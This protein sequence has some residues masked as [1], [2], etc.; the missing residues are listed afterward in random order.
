M[1]QNH[2][3]YIVLIGMQ[4]HSNARPTCD[5]TQRHVELAVCERIAF[6]NQSNI[7]EGLS[8]RLVDAKAVCNDDGVLSAVYGEWQARSLGRNRE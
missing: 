4:H 5:T 3:A 7:A 2:I 6:K 8:L 1:T